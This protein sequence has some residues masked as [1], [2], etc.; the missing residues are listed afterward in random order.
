MVEVGVVR[1]GGLV[2][3]NESAVRI[4]LEFRTPTYNSRRAEEDSVNPPLACPSIAMMN[5]LA[6]LPVYRG[7][8]SAE[9]R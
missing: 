9:E 1:M 7:G 6:L 5:L 4:A 8:V 2:W 3:V